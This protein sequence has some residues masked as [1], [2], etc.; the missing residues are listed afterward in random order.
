MEQLAN[1]L[2][3]FK[4]NQYNIAKGHYRKMACHFKK[5]MKL[6]HWSFKNIINNY[7][8]KATGQGDL[9]IFQVGIRKEYYIFHLVHRTS[10]D[11]YS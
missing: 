2:K 1:L 9:K 6:E 3:N 7:C 11:P 8:Y 4:V 10:I 5:E